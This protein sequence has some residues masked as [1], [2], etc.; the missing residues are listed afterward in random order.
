MTNGTVN[1]LVMWDLR[2]H[3]VSG[4]KM[5]KVLEQAN[6]ITNKNTVVGDKSAFNPG[7]IRLGTG[8]LTTRGFVESDMQIVANFIIRAL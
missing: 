1:H 5:E 8:A 2:P 6:I 3:G 7:G 4:N